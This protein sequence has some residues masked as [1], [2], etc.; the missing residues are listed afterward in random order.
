MAVE[1]LAPALLLNSDDTARGDQYHT[2]RRWTEHICEPLAI[3]DY[4]VQSM[5]DASPVKWHLAHTSWFFE[6]FVLPAARDDYTPFDPRF[7]YLFNS[8]Y[9]AV[10]DRLPRPRRGLLSR[11]TVEEVYR[12]RAHVDVH[13]HALL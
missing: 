9:N 13:V 3:E 5:P 4:I 10:G 8:Y 2:V 11:P 12:Y 6:T 1:S 7:G